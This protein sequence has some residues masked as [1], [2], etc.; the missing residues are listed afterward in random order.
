MQGKKHR[1][2][3]AEDK[4]CCQ[5]YIEYYVMNK[6]S[7]DAATFVG[8]LQKTL[9]D[10]QRSSLKMKVQNIKQI[11]AELGIKDTLLCSPL[12][13]YSMQNKNALMEVLREKGIPAL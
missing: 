8:M 12:R 2:T 3:S 6:S 4:Y 1:W 5:S 10:I 9:P 13:N 7:M 11:V